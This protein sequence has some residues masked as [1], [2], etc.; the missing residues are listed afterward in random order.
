VKRDTIWAEGRKIH[1]A[2]GWPALCCSSSG[3]EGERW[4]VKVSCST[5]F[6]DVAGKQLNV[7]AEFCVLRA[8]ARLNFDNIRMVLFGWKF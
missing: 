7:G 8:A 5:E 3:D 6:G 1:G 4:E 2:G